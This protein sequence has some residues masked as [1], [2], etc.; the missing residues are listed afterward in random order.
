MSRRVAG[1]PRYYVTEGEWDATSYN[2]GEPPFLRRLDDP[3]SYPIVSS[4]VHES[5]LSWS[6]ALFDLDTRHYSGAAQTHSYDATADAQRFLFVYETYPE[7]G[8]R[9]HEL[10]IVQNWFAELRQR[11]AR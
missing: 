6:H 11:V 4:D 5:G 1:D 3:R 9:P 2:P 7:A 8:P 10:Q